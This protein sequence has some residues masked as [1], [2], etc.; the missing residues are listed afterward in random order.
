MVRANQG[1]IGTL[2]AELRRALDGWAERQGP[3][4]RRLAM[5]LAEAVEREEL[6]AGTRL[7][8]ERQLA[9]QLGLGR[10]TVAAAYELL[11]RMSVVERRQGRGT[12]IVARE[13][14]L[15]RG[16]AAELAASLQRNLLFRRLGEPTGE[17]I[18]LIGSCAAPNGA[19]RAAIASA[20]RQ[21]DLDRLACDNGY[22]PLGYPPLRQALARHLSAQGLPT[23]EPEI[24]VTGGAQQAISLVAACYLQPGQVVVLEDPTF[25]GA[26]DAFRTAGARLLTVPVTALG[27]DVDMLGSTVAEHAVRAIYLMPS[28]H[29]PTG[30]VLSEERRRRIAQLSQTTG[31]LVIEDDTEAE[32]GFGRVAPRPIASF[33]EDAP[34]LSIGSMS[35][36]FWGGLRVGWIRGSQSMIGQLGR[37]KA[38]SDLGTSLLSQGVAVELLA[39]VERLRAARRR[40]LAER[41]SLVA[42]LLDV[43]L[44]TWQ[45]RRPAGGL[46]VWARLPDGSASDLAHVAAEHG[47]SIVPGSVMS[48]N[49]RFDE[50]VRLPFDHQ[51]DVLERGLLRLKAAWESYVT[52][53]DVALKGL[54][55]LV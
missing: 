53:D 47:V 11:R 33:A 46:S 2:S 15:V 13:G 28:F 40:E 27:A 14:A 6:L 7:P 18:D 39:D 38:V 34:V 35:K 1:Q 16:R 23:R 52:Q 20:L 4:Y 30:A 29:N 50:Y 19:V 21:L 12:E 43:H 26:I 17:V 24:L 51:P 32:L 9:A 37:L 36:L 54:D 22:F 25:P 44:A 42:E 31:V 48:V 45:W 8:A 5:S 49:A 41:L 3:R 55:V 10:A